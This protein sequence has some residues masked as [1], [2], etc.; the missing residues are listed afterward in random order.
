[1][2]LAVNRQNTLKKSVSNHTVKQVVYAS[3]V[4]RFAVYAIVFHFTGLHP[5]SCK[6]CRSGVVNLVIGVG[7]VQKTEPREIVP[8]LP[9]VRCGGNR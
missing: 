2:N 4:D 3:I 9:R 6:W 8:Y 1:M 5:I 7:V